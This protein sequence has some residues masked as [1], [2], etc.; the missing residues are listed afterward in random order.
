MGPFERVHGGCMPS[1][2]GKNVV[3]H[4]IVGHAKN[5][6]DVLI[7][8]GVPNEYVF[9]IGVIVLGGCTILNLYEST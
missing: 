9:T 7:L 2:N 6:R 8:Q 3:H 1:K 4:K 5:V